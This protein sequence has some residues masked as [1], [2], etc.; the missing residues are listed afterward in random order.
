[1]TM[2][3]T[4][5]ASEDNVVL[6]S[7]TGQDQPGVVASITAIMAGYALEILDVTHSVSHHTI[8]WCMLVRL[9]DSA[10]LN[11][12]AHYCRQCGLAFCHQQLSTADAG[13]WSE[14][15]VSRRFI[16]TLL[17]PVITAEQI[18]AVSD[19]VVKHGLSI[20]NITTLSGPRYQHSCH[21][22]CLEFTLAGSPTHYSALQARLHELTT[23]LNADIVLRNEIL[24]NQ[25]L[26]NLILRNQS[27]R[28]SNRRL[29]V[30]DMDSTLIEAEVIDLLAQAHG[31]GPQVAAITEQAMRGELDFNQSLTRRLA[32]LKGLDESALA[33]IAG[34]L[35]LMAGAER[36]INT[37]KSF[38]YRTAIISGGFTYFARHLQTM[39]G[40]DHAYANEL[41]I[42]AGQLTGRVLG[43]VVDG[44]R[45][46]ELLRQIAAAEG[47]TLE[48]VIAVGDGANDLPMLSIAGLGIAFRAKPLVR[49]LAPHAISTLG[50][51]SIVYLLGGNQSDLHE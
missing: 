42:A 2:R 3:S 10:F 1:M 30:F 31:V 19:M 15:K 7:I 12:M 22:S 37:L 43:T 40:I 18:T 46:A 8:H 32:M 41:E 5:Y 34:Q 35:P 17:S 33:E 28:R 44:Q 36:L 24:Q 47:V 11:A 39:L 29:I 16:M 4:S 45:K 26:R 48:Q 27:A 14:K 38:G 25:I 9:N 23:Q 50:L 13:H 51:D 20:V 6:I 49:R 21:L